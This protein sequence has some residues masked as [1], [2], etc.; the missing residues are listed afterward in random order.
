MKTSALILAAAVL[1][2][3]A[4]QTM[5]TNPKTLKAVQSNGAPPAKGPY[6]QG[7]EVH[8]SRMVFLSGQTARD[9]KTGD[10]V[11]GDI[12]AQT[13]RMMENLKAVLAA[14]GLDFSHVKSRSTPSQFSDRALESARNDH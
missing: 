1:L 5:R 11:T 4:P 2:A 6:S 3:A 10:L 8:G 13:E 7:V 9:P 12:A 14:S